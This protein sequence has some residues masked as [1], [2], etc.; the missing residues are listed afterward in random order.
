MQEKKN[1]LEP[2]HIPQFKN[3]YAAFLLHIPQNYVS[4]QFISPLIIDQ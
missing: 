2:S 4:F 3:A 1:I